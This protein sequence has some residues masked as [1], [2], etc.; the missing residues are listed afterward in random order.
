MTRPSGTLPALCLA[1]VAAVP[2]P[3]APVLAQT[4]AAV[5]SEVHRLGDRRITLYQH[6]FL[7]AQETAA[8]GAMAANEQALTH[9]V[10]GNRQNHAA[11]AVAPRDGFVRN[12]RLAASA[13]AIADLP[14]AEAARD[15]AIAGCER[16]RRR[17][18]GCVVVLE[19]SPV[20]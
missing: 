18:P 10:A 1:L 7:T 16:A 19:V 5:P 12:G 2:V 4:A 9:F 15:A 20:D 8:L 6:P 3:S 11:I 14:S 13:F 17:G